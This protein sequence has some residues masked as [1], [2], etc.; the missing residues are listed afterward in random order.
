MG[1]QFSPLLEF[2]LWLRGQRINEL[3]CK[4]IYHSYIMINAKRET[5]STK[6]KGLQNMYGMNELFL[7]LGGFIKFQDKEKEEY[8]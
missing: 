3:K 5:E 7:P 4:E 8:P 2:T 6:R 1:K